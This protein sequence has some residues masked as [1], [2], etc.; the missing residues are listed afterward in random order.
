MDCA[1]LGHGAVP[2]WGCIWELWEADGRQVIESTNQGEVDREPWM[3]IRDSYLMQWGV[4][5][6]TRRGEIVDHRHV[7][8]VGVKIRL[9][10]KLDT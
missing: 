3:L 1:E 2:W 7:G 4:D 10:I 8:H 5:H 6:V 9:L